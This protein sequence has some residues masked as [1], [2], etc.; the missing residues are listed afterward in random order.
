MRR[1]AWHHRGVFI[2]IH[3]CGFFIKRL[4]KRIAIVDVAIHGFDEG[5]FFERTIKE[6]SLE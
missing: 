5:W 1:Y 4:L 3:S 2:C 6:V